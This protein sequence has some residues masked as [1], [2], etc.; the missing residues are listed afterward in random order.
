MDGV[1]LESL[2]QFPSAIKLSMLDKNSNTP[3][4]TGVPAAYSFL[5]VLVS[6]RNR[7]STKHRKQSLG[8]ST[9]RIHQL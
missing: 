3:I 9:T 7:G 6:N 1:S 2:Q 5:I 8:F 4:S